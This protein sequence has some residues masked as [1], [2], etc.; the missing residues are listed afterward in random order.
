VFRW[1]NSWGP[2]YGTNGNGWIRYE[3]LRDLLADDGEACIP[4]Q[5][6][7]VRLAA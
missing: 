4:L 6:S 2:D 5:R 3:D 7:R 1:R